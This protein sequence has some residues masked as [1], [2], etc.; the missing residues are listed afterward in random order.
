MKRLGIV[1]CA[2]VCAGLFAQA[3]VQAGVWRVRQNYS[4]QG[5]N[6]TYTNMPDYIEPAA[7]AANAVFGGTT[8]NDTWNAWD[9]DARNGNMGGWNYIQGV[10]TS[11]WSGGGSGY[12][13]LYDGTGTG[14]PVQI[15]SISGSQQHNGWVTLPTTGSGFQQLVGGEHSAGTNSGSGTG[16]YSVQISGLTAG[17]NFLFYSYAHRVSGGHGAYL[18]NLDGAAST[19]VTQNVY[20]EGDALSGV[21][22][23]TTV[24]GSGS[25]VVNYSQAGMTGPAFQFATVTPVPEPSAFVLAG[26]GLV[27]LSFGALRKRKR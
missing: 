16:S 7:A 20:S 3:V 1:A 11:P 19:T 18:V 10:Q 14:N 22:L 13:T 2:I 6:L 26:L 12:S 27:G 23:S 25:V 9:V 24:P 15:R 17:D 5:G 4:D 8:S 21:L